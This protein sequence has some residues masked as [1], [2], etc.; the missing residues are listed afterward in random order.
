VKRELYNFL[1]QISK[2]PF[3][4]LIIS[5]TIQ[6]N[7]LIFI[8]V[9]YVQFWFKIRLNR[10]NSLLRVCYD[11]LKGTQ[12][13]LKR[14]WYID[15]K[16]LLDKYEIGYI[17]DTDHEIVDDIEHST[18]TSQINVALYSMYSKIQQNWILRMQSSGTV[19]QYKYLKT[20][21]YIADYLN[22]SVNWSITR[23]V[24]QLRSNFPR[25]RVSGKTVEF[26]EMKYMLCNRKN[27]S[28]RFCDNNK[29]ENLFHVLFECKMYQYVR[30]KFLSN[31]TFPSRV[32]CIYQFFT[33][34][35]DVK[36]TN[37]YCFMTYVC[38]IRG[39]WN[40]DP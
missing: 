35:C 14:N 9:F 27:R 40:E 17:L 30:Q 10:K 15:F 19:N 8:L 2:P 36:A 11:S 39:A 20:H 37:I 4:A 38:K 12:A 3:K 31:Y 5:D 7:K 34:I 18:V 21:V 6:V 13:K 33:D 1:W 29:I 26:N 24:L 22:S 28:C 32:E 16:N 23:L 25:I